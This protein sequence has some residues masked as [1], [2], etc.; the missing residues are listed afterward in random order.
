M[1][2]KV[3]G[4]TLVGFKEVGDRECYLCFEDGTIVMFEVDNE[5]DHVWLSVKV[6]SNDGWITLDSEE[7][8]DE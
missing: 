2:H 4:K 3:L 5:Y 1:L 6:N 8:K 7:V